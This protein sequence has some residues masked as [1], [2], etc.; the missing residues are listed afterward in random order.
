LPPGV[1]PRKRWTIRTLSLSKR[2][3]P[4]AAQKK[5]EALRATSNETYSKAYSAYQQKYPQLSWTINNRPKNAFE[6]VNPLCTKEKFRC[7]NIRQRGLND[8]RRGRQTSTTSLPTEIP[9]APVENFI[10]SAWHATCYDIRLACL[11][12]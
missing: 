10:I 11:S 2:P 1:A 5:N 3:S 6:I 7:S 9:T 4:G 8:V 12:Y